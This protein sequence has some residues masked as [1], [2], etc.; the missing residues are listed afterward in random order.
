[1]KKGIKGGRCNLTAC[2]T[3]DEPA[4]WYNH[5]SRAYYCEGCAKM[6]NEDPF[7]KRD[8]QEMFGHPLCTIEEK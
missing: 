2:Q 4:E 5:G 3:P 6:L 8:A 7:N 1:M